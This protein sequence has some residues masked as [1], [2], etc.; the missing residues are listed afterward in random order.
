MK[1]NPSV[2]KMFPGAVTSQGFFSHYNYIIE[3]DALH[4]FV[5][6]GGPG[7]GKSTFMK[8]IAESML[9]M[10]Y[11]LE[12][13]CCSSDNNSIDG[14]VIP[15]LRIALM[16]G[17]S[18]HI[19]DPKNPGAVDEIINLGEYWDE[20]VIQKAKP[21]IMHCNYQ[22]S[23][24]FQAAYLALREAQVALEEWEFYVKEFQNWQVINQ[25]TL[26][27]EKNLFSAGKGRNGK[28]RHLFAWSHTPQGKVQYIDTLLKDISTLYTLEG[29]PGTGKSTFLSRMAER[30][31]THG[32]NV[33]YYHNILE[34]AKLDLIIIPELHLAMSVVS[35]PYEYTP[36]FSGRQITLDFDQSVNMIGLADFAG[37]IE[38]CRERVNKNIERAIKNSSRAKATHDLLETYYVAAMDFP[39][40]EKKRREIEARIL[41]MIDL[42]IAVNAAGSA[43]PDKT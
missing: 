4:I 35:E 19:V 42:D 13:H 6:K 18:P 27:V 38:D 23:R 36:K 33:E 29:Q 9:K 11:D 1:A 10:G 7:V 43:L 16:D 17:T 37:D 14:L 20:N 15:S 30:A 40:I 12:Y 5:I 41:N 39:A 2:R 25:I 21:K 31:G 3:P 22:I 26:N 8:K 32:F 24:Y 34:P 28:G